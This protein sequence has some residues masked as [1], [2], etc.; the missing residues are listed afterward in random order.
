MRLRELFE[1]VNA[2]K[3]IG[4]CFGRW[5]PPHK[6]H[7]AAWETAAQFNEWYVGT[8]HNTQGPDDP[9]P[10]EVKLQCMK[11]ILP[12]VVGHVIPETN[13]FTL[14]ARIYASHGENVHLKV[15]TDEAWLTSAL[16]KYNGK[17]GNHG[18]YKFASI[19]HEPTPRLSS[20]TALR[21]AVRQGD[22]E[23]FSAA[24]GVPW[25]TAIK[26]EGRNKRFFD[27]VAHYLKQFPEKEKKEKKL[28]EK[29]GLFR[30]GAAGKVGKGGTTPI[31]KEKKAAMRNA[32]TM[33]GL[34]MATGSMYKNYRMGIALAGAPTFPTK[35]AADNWIG[36]DPLISS[37]T[38]EEYEMVKAA[39]LQVGAGTIENWSGKR[40]EEMADTNK[41]SSVAK[42][43]K[44]K[45][46]V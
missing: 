43:K 39:A 23:A 14:A 18:Y 30:E 33:P 25:D 17:E 2:G 11:A 8:N 13:L 16:E 7:A 27:V 46:G 40:S 3:T 37:Y 4:V 31:D 22:K 42:I 5:N 20:A 28:K 45:Y 15:C 19:G 9:L 35:M 26:V 1:N 12:E 32:T 36:G 29:I 10:Y 34:N 6:G 41:T 38:E 24:A 21:A 44:N